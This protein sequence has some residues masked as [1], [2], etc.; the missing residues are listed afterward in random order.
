MGSKGSSLLTERD[1]SINDMAEFLAK[2]A[3]E[4]HRVPPSIRKQI[5]EEHKHAEQVAIWVGRAKSLVSGD[6]PDIGKDSC[7]SGFDK[8]NNGY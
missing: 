5:A 8:R 3:V 4:E 6:F 2:S 7:V 1:R